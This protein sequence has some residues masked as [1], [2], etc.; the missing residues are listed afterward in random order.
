[1]GYMLLKSMLMKR[2]YP[3]M[4]S[5]GSNPTVNEDVSFR[6]IEVHILNLIMTFMGI[7]LQSFSEKG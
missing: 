4:L 7:I 3:G 2:R 6:S 5:I 1:M